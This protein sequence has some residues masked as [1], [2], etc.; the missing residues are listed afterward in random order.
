M[1]IDTF[2]SRKN[3]PSRCKWYKRDNKALNVL[4]IDKTLKGVFYARDIEPV[5]CEKILVGSSMST[6]YTAYIETPD[7]IRGIE[8]DDY[9]KYDGEIWHVISAIADDASNQKAYSKRPSILT[10]IRMVR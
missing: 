3:Y 4:E 8:P 5:K 10:K 7:V 9:V 6:Q 2:T 1:G